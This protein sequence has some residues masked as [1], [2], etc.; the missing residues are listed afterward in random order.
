MG[1]VSLRCGD[2]RVLFLRLGI[3]IRYWD[4]AFFT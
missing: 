1:L 2:E 3:F 4:F